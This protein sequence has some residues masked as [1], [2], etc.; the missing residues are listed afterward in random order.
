M[1]VTLVG[2]WPSVSIS[3][4]TPSGDKP[5]GGLRSRYG[6]LPKSCFDLE[7]WL[8]LPNDNAFGTHLVSTTDVGAGQDHEQTTTVHLVSCALHAACLTPLK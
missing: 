1:E 4:T 2:K 5:S 3:L 6:K 7:F 8:G